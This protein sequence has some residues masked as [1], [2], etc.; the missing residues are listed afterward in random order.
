MHQAKVHVLDHHQR[1]AMRL[2]LIDH[3]RGGSLTHSMACSAPTTL[4]LVKRSALLGCDPAQVGGISRQ[5]WWILLGLLY[6]QSTIALIC[7]V[8]LLYGDP[9]V[10]H[11]SQKT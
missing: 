6:S 3:E 7:L 1:E 8:G 10:V 11:R 2:A 9:G 4:F 5:V